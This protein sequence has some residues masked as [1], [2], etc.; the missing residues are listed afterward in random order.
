MKKTETKGTAK[1]ELTATHSSSFD[2]LGPNPH[3]H[4]PVTHVHRPTR[5]YAQDG[6][7]TSAAIISERCTV[8]ASVDC[9]DPDGPTYNGSGWDHDGADQRIE[10]SVCTQLISS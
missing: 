8:H 2:E 5:H 1:W 3:S 6:V 9:L 10:C 7:T 4:G